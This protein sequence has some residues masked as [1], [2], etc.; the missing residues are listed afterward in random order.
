MII[1]KKNRTI[2]CFAAYHGVRKTRFGAYKLASKYKFTSHARSTQPKMAT[3]FSYLVLPGLQNVSGLYHWGQN[4]KILKFCTELIVCS[5]ESTWRDKQTDRQVKC[6]ISKTF[7]NIR[8]KAGDYHGHF[9]FSL[10]S[11]YILIVEYR[12]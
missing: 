2:L 5:F 3:Q 7:E 1:L 4:F 9:A 12:D 10:A 6:S 8:G 11:F